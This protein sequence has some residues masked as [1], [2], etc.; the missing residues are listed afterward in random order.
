MM[1][2]RIVSVFLIGGSSTPLSWQ[3]SRIS[4]AVGCLCL[5]VDQCNDFL[6][7]L[8]RAFLLYKLSCDGQDGDVIVRVAG[9]VSCANK[10]VFYTSYVDSAACVGIEESS[11]G[12]INLRGGGLFHFLRA[13]VV[14]CWFAF[15]CRCL[16]ALLRW[17][18]SRLLSCFCRRR[19]RQI[20]ITALEGGHG[21]IRRYFRAAFYRGRSTRCQVETS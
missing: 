2:A 3:G 5:F 18:R 10:L 21:G 15:A 6:N 8:V 19:G 1:T 9:G 14:R 13:T 11:I 20:A 16:S 7:V 17:L 4:L 12:S